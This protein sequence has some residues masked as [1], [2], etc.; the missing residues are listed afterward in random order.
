MVLMSALLLAHS[1]SGLKEGEEWSGVEERGAASISL[2]R[3]SSLQEF[4]SC[5]PR[6]SEDHLTVAYYG[7]C[8]ALL[9]HVL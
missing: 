4:I 1:S 5:G 2:V 3:Y 8:A 9:G 7:R 6:D